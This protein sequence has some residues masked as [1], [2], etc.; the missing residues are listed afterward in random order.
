MSDITEKLLTLTLNANWQPVGQKL[1]KDALCDLFGG[2][3]YD[4][5]DIE[6]DIDE[7]GDYDFNSPL[8]MNPVKWD[9]WVK[10]PVRD[11]DFTVSSTKMTIRVPTILIAKN[12]AKMP[13]KKPRLSKNGIYK[14]DNGVCQYT[15]RRVDRRNGNIDHVVPRSRGGRDTWDNMVFCSKNI[16]DKKQNK[17]PKEAGLKLIRDPKEP[18]P[19]PASAFIRNAKHPDWSH[20]IVA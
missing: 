18:L 1:V 6:Y 11:F 20:F 3:S 10:L 4:A 2:D 16:N 9:D 12:Y 19:K 13:I 5:L 14:R 8:Y 15:G 7:N 17:L